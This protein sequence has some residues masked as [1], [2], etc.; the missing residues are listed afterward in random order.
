M[1]KGRIL[2]SHLNAL[3]GRIGHGDLIVIS[4]AGMPVPTGTEKID[5]AVEKDYPDI[6]SVLEVLLSDMI[7]ER[8]VV[9]EEQKKY[10][11]LLY[12]K[13]SP[14]IKRCG[15]DLLPHEELFSDLLPK[16]T[17]VIRTGS[18]EPWGNIFLV[19]GIDAAAW[20]EKEGVST[21]DYYQER[22][23]YREE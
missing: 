10:N 17:A 12:S 19:S 21:P 18:F 23:S 3:L 14:H 1:K 4:D 20:F 11:P 5:L 22:A 8:V 13:I 6:V 9:A 7:Y 16:A 15:I 2:N